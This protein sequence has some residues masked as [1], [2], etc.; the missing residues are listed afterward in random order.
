VPKPGLKP[1]ISDDPERFDEAVDEFRKRVPLTEEEYESILEEE[2]VRAFTVAGAAQADLV[3]QVYEAIDSAIEQG[4]TFEE[5][6]D[7]VGDALESAWGGEIPGRLETIFRT[8]VQTAYSHG[9]YKIMTS[10]AVKE[11]RPYWRAEVVDD[12][13]TS[14]ICEEL[15]GVVLPADDPFWDDH[16]PPLHFNCRTVLSPLS[17]EEAADE[18]VAEEEPDTDADEGFGGT[19]DEDDWEPD[20]EDYPA[21][22]ADDV[23]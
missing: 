16:I 19:P 22:I 1:S 14:D 10:K 12:D 5:F 9:R 21:E 15:I 4:T 11:A 2:R 23:P 3:T 7:Q 8:N 17:A 6:K 20:A 18:G 13:R